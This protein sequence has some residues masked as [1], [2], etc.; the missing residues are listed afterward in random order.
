MDLDL[1]KVLWVLFF[2]KRKGSKNDLEYDKIFS[3]LN[4]AELYNLKRLIK[5]IN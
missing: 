4:L 5:C 2:L 3:Q 1:D